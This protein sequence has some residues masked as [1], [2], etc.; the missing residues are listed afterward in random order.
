MRQ[1]GPHAFFLRGDLGPRC[2]EEPIKDENSPANANDG[3]ESHGHKSNLLSNNPGAY[4]H[5]RSPEYQFLSLWTVRILRRGPTQCRVLTL[6]G[7][8]FGSARTVTRT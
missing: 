3:I 7:V 2:A 4:F 5:P 1:A 6:F 8:A